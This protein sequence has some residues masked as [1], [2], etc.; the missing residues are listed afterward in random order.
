[1]DKMDEM[2]LVIKRSDLFDGVFA[3]ELAFQ[4]TET[5]ADL[6]HRL[7]ERLNSHME[8][9]R[10]GDAEDN[11]TYKQP[12]PYAIIRRDNEIFTYKRLSGGGETRLHDK[13]SIGVGGHMNAI[14]GESFHGVLNRNLWRE[15]DEELVFDAHDTDGFLSKETIGFIN[16]DENE[17]GRVHIGLLIILDMAYDADV[18]VRETDQL[19][20]EWMTMEQLL[21]PDVYARLESWS[22]I[23]VDT[24]K[25]ET[26]G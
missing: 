15:L 24:L 16:D 6:I 4:G 2:I 22:Q 20:G 25:K 23:A 14:E 9:M 7:S 17:V 1:M 3:D 21:S 10:R 18:N 5:D 19:E 11:Q 12:I 13:L 26:N 8:I